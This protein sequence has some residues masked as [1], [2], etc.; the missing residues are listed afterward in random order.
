MSI[1]SEYFLRMKPDFKKLL[2][3]GFKENGGDYAFS[4]DFLDGS[5]RAEIVI[6]SNGDVRGKII[7]ADTDDEYM[8]ARI[9]S[10]NGVF[11]TTVRNAYCN[12]LHEIAEKCF[13]HLTFIHEQAN[14]ITALI[15]DKYGDKPDFPFDKLT[16]H[17]VFR[18]P[19][20]RKW[21]ALILNIRKTLLNKTAADKAETD[22]DE[23]VE[24]LNLKVIPEQINSLLSTAGIYPAYH[25]N[26]ANWVSIILNETV[27]DSF[28]MDL[29]E[30]SHKFTENAAKTKTVH[31]GCI[32]W[33][34]PANPKFY[35]IEKAF[36]KQDTID[37]KQS[38]NIKTGDIVYIYAAA[39]VSGILY[40][41]LAVKVNI[42]CDY[43]DKNLK[44]S[45]VMKIK[46]IERF[47]RG[48]FDF[49]WLNKH[50]IKTVRGPRILPDDVVAAINH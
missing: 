37:W 3:Y 27:S 47:S 31:A 13:N 36:K 21:Y 4:T 41:C 5:F 29:I 11:V 7:E 16:K 2:Q 6:N 20:N 18:N 26:R 44:I 19:S 42:P 22:S 24:V 23:M 14:R 46:L 8:P 28:I 25:M 10:M 32:N 38:S 45:K 17:G 49:E 35:D 34:I 33:I 1:E 48:A 43:K 12:I 39:P 40:K 15:G 50:G 9:V 30:I